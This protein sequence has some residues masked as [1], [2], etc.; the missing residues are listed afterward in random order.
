MARPSIK[1]TEEDRKL[2]ES[3]SGYGVPHEN[4]C[5]LVCGGINNDT[6]KKYF[7]K[8]LDQ[9][10]AKANAKVGQTLFQKAVAGDTTAAIWWSKTQMGW[11]ETKKVEHSGEIARKL[12]DFYGDKL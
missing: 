4:I 9:G 2:V 6:L 3:M 1:P 5:A 11:S 10:K 8:E 7:K 12:E